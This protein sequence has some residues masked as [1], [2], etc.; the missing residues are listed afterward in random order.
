MLIIFLCL[1]SIFVVLSLVYMSLYSGYSVYSYIFHRIIL[2][3]CLSSYWLDYILLG[4][5]RITNGDKS[6]CPLEDSTF[7][8][9]FQNIILDIKSCLSWSRQRLQNNVLIT[10]R[11]PSSVR[12]KVAAKWM[13]HSLEWC[14]CA[15]SGFGIKSSSKG[16]LSQLLE[17]KIAWRNSKLLQAIAN[18]C[19]S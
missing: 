15:P 13:S 14:C 19:L 3:F 12:L 4:I 1:S 9:S 7:L 10:S 11:L 16:S 17:L 5:E 2:F 8:I 18:A 6:G